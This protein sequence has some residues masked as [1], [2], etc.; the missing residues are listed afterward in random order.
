[1]SLDEKGVGESVGRAL[2]GLGRSRKQG[3]LAALR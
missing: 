3:L 1:M 2:K